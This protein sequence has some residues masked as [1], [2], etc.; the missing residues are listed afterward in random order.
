MTR[1]ANDIALLE[2]AATIAGRAI[3]LEGDQV[4]VPAETLYALADELKAARFGGAEYR[5]IGDEAVWLVKA[6]RHVVIEREDGNAAMG[7]RWTRL[8]QMLASCVALDLEN[9]K[10]RLERLT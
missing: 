9:A 2:R 3:W 10:K 1:L 6:A 4:S 8:A 5:L 7:E